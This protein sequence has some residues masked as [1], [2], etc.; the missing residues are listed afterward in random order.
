MIFLYQTPGSR[1]VVEKLLI[2]RPVKKFP[3][4]YGTLMVHYCV[5]NSPLFL[6]RAR[7]IPLILFL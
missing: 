7:L 4:P 3:T 1:V 5:Y 6:F 2:A